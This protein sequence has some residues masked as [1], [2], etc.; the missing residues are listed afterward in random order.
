MDFLFNVGNDRRAYQGIRKFLVAPNVSFPNKITHSKFIVV[1]AAL[2]G[3]E[4]SDH[5]KGIL[6]SI[7]RVAAFDPY[8]ASVLALPNIVPVPRALPSLTVRRGH[9]PSRG[10]ARRS[11]A[12]SERAP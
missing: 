4:V 7:Y 1:R 10:V 8:Y 6:R 12:A 9:V 3:G 11:E 5:E 2:Q